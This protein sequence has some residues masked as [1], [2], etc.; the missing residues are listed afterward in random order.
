MAVNGV[1]TIVLGL[2]ILLSC[3]PPAWGQQPQVAAE[4]AGRLVEQLRRN[5]A[6]PS[7]AAGQIGLY[8][9]DTSGGEPTL[10]ASE[11]EPTYCQCGSSAWSRDGKRI[12][13]DAT[14]G[15]NDHASTRIKAIFLENGHPVRGRPRPGQLP[16]SL[17]NRRSGHFLWKPRAPSRT[18]RWASGS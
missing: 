11:P 8:V 5:P 14:L 10:I 15:N 17:A 12:Y 9:I 7:M 4:A 13:F 18:R 2:A 1:K 6:T 16:E 3:W